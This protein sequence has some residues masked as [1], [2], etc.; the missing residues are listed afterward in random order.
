VL[1]FRRHVERNFSKHR[2]YQRA[3]ILVDAVK[4]NIISRIRVGDKDITIA[5]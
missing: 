1:D 4:L 2:H 3:E 5:F